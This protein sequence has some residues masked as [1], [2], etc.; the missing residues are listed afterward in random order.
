M[1]PYLIGLWVLAA[2]GRWVAR[3]VLDL[4][5]VGL[6]TL[7]SQLATVVGLVGRAA[8][9]AWSPNSYALF[10]EG[11]VE[12]AKAYLRRQ[13]TRTVAAVAGIA[14]LAFFGAA[15]TL[16]LM[17]PQYSECLGILPIMLIAPVLDVA[18]LR[19]HNTLLGVKQTKVIGLYTTISIASFLG[20]AWAGTRLFG[21]VGLSLAYV[22][23]YT[24]QW[25]MARVAAAHVVRSVAPRTKLNAAIP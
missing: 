18:H 10:A 6:F 21:L 13:G 22:G 4:H 20:L 19:Y 8:Y 2:G 9:E 14:V 11:N 16:P 15:V 17:A 12:L 5:A 1:L 24:L 23:A 3:G 7:A 25:T